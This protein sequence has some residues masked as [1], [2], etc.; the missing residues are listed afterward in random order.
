MPR[1]PTGRPRGRPAKPPVAPAPKRP[2][3]RPPGQTE[4]LAPALWLRLSPA[5]RVEVEARA[6][7]AGV[8]LS[9][10]VRRLVRRALGL[11]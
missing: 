1:K 2:R 4:P 10:W 9:A 11:G 3:G 6:V 5:E 8:S 7:A